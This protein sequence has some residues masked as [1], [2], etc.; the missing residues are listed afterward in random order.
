MSNI[1]TKCDNN[2]HDHLKK[3]RYKNYMINRFK[4]VDKKQESVSFIDFILDK[5]Q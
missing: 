1:L 4:H 2:N 5:K 3:D